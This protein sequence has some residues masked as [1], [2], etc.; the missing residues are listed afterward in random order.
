MLRRAFRGD[1][2]KP[3]LDY[4]RDCKLIGFAHLGAD[5]N[6]QWRSSS[7]TEPAASYQ[8]AS[9]ARGHPYSARQGPRQRPHPWVRGECLQY[10][11]VR[12]QGVVELSFGM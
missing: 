11:Q 2:M 7:K 5:A 12:F 4:L 10:P 8:G 9:L 3:V 1:L 6:T